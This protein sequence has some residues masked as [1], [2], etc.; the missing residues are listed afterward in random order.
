[1]AS[2]TQADKASANLDLG[3]SVILYNWSALSI[4]VQNQWGGP[5]STE[6]R[7]W[8]CAEIPE[9]LRNRPETDDIDLEEILMNV[10]MDEFD[11]AVEDDSGAL[12]AEE[13][14][15]VRDWCVRGEFDKVQ[16]LWEEYDKKQKKGGD[17]NVMQGKTENDDEDDE[18]DEEEGE[19]D[20]EMTD[21]APTRPPREKIEPEV[22][23][24]G[25]TTVV[26][27]KRR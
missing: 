12:V 10:M 25:F 26:S 15:K 13:I 18:D 14:I 24:D 4:A 16:A 11:V 21:A 5:K 27:R 17:V 9:I 1:M 7:D 6:K 2:Q 22:D 23:E 20:T 19:E 8:L 3:V